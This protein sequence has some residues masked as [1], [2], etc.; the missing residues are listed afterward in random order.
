VLEKGTLVYEVKDG[1]YDASD[2]KFFAP[3]ARRRARR[4]RRS[5]RRKFLK[6]NDPGMS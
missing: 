5:I 2:D 3:W 4:E 1:P 6:N